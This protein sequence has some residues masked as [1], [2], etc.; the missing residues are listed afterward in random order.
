MIEINDPAF[1]IGF[2]L[3]AVCLSLWLIAIERNPEQ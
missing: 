1:C 3:S 2:I